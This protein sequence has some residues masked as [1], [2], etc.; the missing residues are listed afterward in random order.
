MHSLIVYLSY[1]QIYHHQQLHCRTTAESSSSSSSSIAAAA[2]TR[3]INPARGS[4]PKPPP[5][6]CRAPAARAVTS[7]CFCRTRLR[8]AAPHPM[9]SPFP[10]FSLARDAGAPR[11]APLRNPAGVPCRPS[12]AAA[13]RGHVFARRRLK[14][15]GHAVPAGHEAAPKGPAPGSNNA[16]R[17]AGL[18][19]CEPSPVVGPAARSGRT[20]TA[21]AE[22]RARGRLAPSRT[23]RP[24][25]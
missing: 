17:S 1:H 6:G 4:R 20:A 3:A 7:S 24:P 11:A 9:R 12:A 23:E 25:G 2:H 13:P 16:R 21:A 15:R 8:S 22:A 10:L 18:T 19:T 14:K 5:W